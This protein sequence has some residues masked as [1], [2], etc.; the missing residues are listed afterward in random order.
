MLY[1]LGQLLADITGMDEVTTQPL[2]GA[3]GE[4]TGI[5]L[6]SAYHAAKGNKAKQN[7][8]AD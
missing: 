8:I 4:M 1:D 3:H 7:S 6:I 5:M 2:A